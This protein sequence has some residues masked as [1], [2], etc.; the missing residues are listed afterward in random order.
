MSKYIGTRLQECTH[1]LTLVPWAN[2]WHFALA[3]KQA[4]ASY[5]HRKEADIATHTKD[6]VRFNLVHA[7]VPS[8][9]QRS[10]DS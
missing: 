7:C 6:V 9:C 1:M 10:F 8:A 2:R 4:F 5:F 3:Q